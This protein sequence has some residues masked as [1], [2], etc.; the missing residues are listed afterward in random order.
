MTHDVA[1]AGK[2]GGTAR[3]GRRVSAPGPRSSAP[4]RRRSRPPPALYRSGG[5]RLC[6]GGPD[7][8]G[9][10]S[11]ARDAGHSAWWTIASAILALATGQRGAGPLEH[12]PG[13]RG[14]RAAGARAASAWHERRPARRGATASSS[15]SIWRS[16]PTALAELR[17]DIEAFAPRRADVAAELRTGF[18]RLAGSGGSYGFPEISAIAREV[19]QSVRR[20]R[21]QPRGRTG[22]TQAVRRL[23]AALTVGA[24]AGGHRPEVAAGRGL[25]AVLVL[26]A[27][28]DRDRVTPRRSSA[29]D[30][31]C[32]L[33]GRPRMTAHDAG[34]ERLDLLVI[35][36]AAGRGRPFR[37]R[38]RVDQPPL[39]PAA[40]GDADRDAQGGG[41]AA[42]RGRG[43]GCGVPRRADGGGPAA[44]CAHA[45]P[46]GPPPSTVLLRRR[47]MRIAQPGGRRTWSRRTSGW[48]AVHPP[49]A[50]RELLD[51]EVPDLLLLAAP[52]LPDGDGFSRARDVRQDPRFHLL[53]SLVIGSRRPGR[54]RSRPFAPAPT[55]SCPTPLDAELLLQTVITRAERG[56]RLR[57]MLL[58][59]GLT[60]P[61]Q[62]RDAAGGAG[63]R[64]GVRPAARR[65]ARLRWC[66]TSTASARS[67]SG[68]ARSWATRSCCHVANVFRSSV[69]ASDVIG[70]YGGGGV[71]A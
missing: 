13:I 57:E 8:A 22:S 68:S 56:R 26:P 41:S 31:T 32:D 62:S 29:Q 28:A 16:Y 63:V 33:R 69:R 30:S 61:A 43:R 27:G 46:S 10:P 24:S 55:T 25:R 44:L 64:G 53:P 65:P 59:D 15:A 45:G 49:Q 18:H 36:T 35:G 4:L 58:R 60:G 6:D 7:L 67:T 40:R 54:R 51:R 11:L 71:R 5:A 12:R 20:A 52:R 48:C 70:R 34:D 1:R 66:S 23:E 2:L 42:G 39:D 50:A 9:R 14:R 17:K 21:L 37:R 38:L 47:A 19:E 3:P